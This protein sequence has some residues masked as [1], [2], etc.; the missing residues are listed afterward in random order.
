MHQHLAYCHQ[1]GGW[2]LAH[3]CIEPLQLRGTACHEQKHQYRQW[4]WQQLSTR[5]GPS[6][7][8]YLLLRLLS[9]HYLVLSC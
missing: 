9:G 1:P 3:C 5:A 7:K 8:T 6:E 2:H 4:V